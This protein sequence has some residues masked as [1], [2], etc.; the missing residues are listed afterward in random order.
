MQMRN[1]ER[2]WGSVQMALHWLVVVAVLSQLTLGIIFA[3]L[4]E[5]DPRG[6][7]LFAAHATLGLV[8]LVLMLAR[9]IWRQRN[10]VPALPDTLEP[11]QK[12]I[13][14]ANHW[15]FYV[16][17]IALPISGYLMVNTHGFAVPFFGVRLPVLLPKNET[18]GD[19][20]L[21]LHVG[22]AILLIALVMLHVAAALR[23]EFILKDNTLRRMTPLAP[24][25]ESAAWRSMVDKP[26]TRSAHRH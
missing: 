2:G 25:T 3:N 26:R 12:K 10:P 18:L 24:R 21:Y 15:A 9:F 8:I 7:T 17:L 22:G 4:P 16:L 13:A 19:V 23:H 11:Y 5:H 14:L 6:K 1:T 20:F